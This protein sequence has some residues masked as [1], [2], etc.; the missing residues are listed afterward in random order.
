M[1]VCVKHVHAESATICSL[2][3]LAYQFQAHKREWIYFTFLHIA[4]VFVRE[5]SRLNGQSEPL[6]H[7]YMGDFA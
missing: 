6:R 7:L 3:T 1:Q 2:H 4:S 5:S